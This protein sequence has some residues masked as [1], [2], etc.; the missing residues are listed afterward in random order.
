MHYL[1]GL[2]AITNLKAKRA[3]L[4]EEKHR[5]LRKVRVI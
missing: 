2:V 4:L 1:S 3:M 5:P